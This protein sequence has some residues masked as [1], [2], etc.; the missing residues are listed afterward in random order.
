MSDLD[1]IQWDAPQSQP[2]ASSA[3]SSIKWDDSTPALPSA[4]ATP[5]VPF[6]TAAGG[7]ANLTP[8]QAQDYYRNLQATPLNA[9]APEEQGVMRRAVGGLLEPYTGIAA[10]LEKGAATAAD[11]L[12]ATGASK[13]LQNAAQNSYLYG[14]QTQPGVVSGAA[15]MVGGLPEMILPGAGSVAAGA[16]TAANELM[17]ATQNDQPL[18]MKELTTAL[19]SG[20][21]DAAMNYLLGKGVSGPIAKDL[22]RQLPMAL[23]ETGA[24]V[25]GRAG[26]GAILG[27][28]GQAVQ[29]LIHG[30]PLSTG[31]VGAAGQ[32]GA[33]E[34]GGGFAHDLAT[35]GSD[36][37]ARANAQPATNVPDT[38]IEVNGEN[39]PAASSRM[40]TPEDHD[41]IRAAM[42]SLKGTLNDTARAQSD[43]MAQGKEFANPEPQ[44]AGLSADEVAAQAAQVDPDVK[45]GGDDIGATHS[46]FKG[47]L[48][49]AHGANAKYSLQDIPLDS[50]K[51]NENYQP[52]KVQE[53][54]QQSAD[55]APPI[56]M[57]KEGAVVDGNTR[58]RAALARGDTTIKGY[59]PVTGDESISVKGQETAPPANQTTP[60]NAAIQE[61]TPFQQ[62]TLGSAVAAKADQWKQGV[63]EAWKAANRLMGTGLG[64]GEEEQGV[65]QRL[66]ATGSQIDAD[67][68]TLE[69]VMKPD[70]DAMDS[71][72]P[73]KR[74][75]WTNAVESGK[76]VQDAPDAANAIRT[77]N[78]SLAQRAEQVGIDTNNWRGDWVGRLAEWPDGT[79]GAGTTLAGPENYLKGR[80]LATF[81]DF[82]NAVEETGGRLTYDNPVDMYL[83]KAAEVNKSLT[84]REFLQ[85]EQDRGT[86]RTLG[87]GEKPAENEGRIT[88]PLGRE[89]RL[90]APKPI[91]DMLNQFI[92]P[93]IPKQ[94]IFARLAEVSRLTTGANFALSAFHAA[95]TG[96]SNAY[97]GVRQSLDN[98][99][100]GEFSLAAKNLGRAV[101][102]VGNVMW[103]NELR[104]QLA[105]MKDSPELKPLADAIRES[106]AKSG[107]PSILDRTSWQKA[108]NAYRQGDSAEAG[109]RFMQSGAGAISHVIMDKLVPNAKMA[110]LGMAAETATKRRLEGP[111]LQKYMQDASRLT[112]NVAGQVVRS[113]QFQH[114][115]VQN[116]M[117]LVMSA[118]K[119]AEG[120]IRV[121][122]GAAVDT[123]K[124]LSDVVQGNAP[125]ITA[126]QQA[127]L[128]HLLVHGTIAAV[129]QAMTTAA[130]GQMQLPSSFKDLWYPK[131]GRKNAD[132]S[133]ERLSLP[134]P[135]GVI[136]ALAAEGPKKALVN[137]INPVWRA[138]GD[139]ISNSDY[140]NVQ[141]RSGNVAEQALQSAGH[142]GKAILPWSVQQ[143]A[144]PAN[145]NQP[146]PSAVERGAAF[147]G[148]RK[149][150][151]SVSQSPAEQLAHEL[152]YAPGQPRPEADADRAST[153]SALANGIRNKEPDARAKIS[154]AVQSGTIQ[155]SDRKTIFERS[156]GPAGLAGTLYHSSLTP[157]QLMQVWGKAS[158]EE[159]QMIRGVV[160]RRIM[161]STS[162]SSDQRRAYRVQIQSDMAGGQ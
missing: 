120:A 31:L 46:Y 60:D 34:V 70:R 85:G 76:D 94:S 157:D 64:V 106:G 12:G 49:S 36:Q 42:E 128:A 61:K 148:V 47:E 48:D 136:P 71:W 5:T 152:S 13:A 40:P 107:T 100:H 33:M 41:Q 19:A 32:G 83:A 30:Q 134:D 23:G 88:D 63:G 25:V 68:A 11:A 89:D 20:G 14:A 79:K 55:T 98:V 90:V 138:I 130:N 109:L 111:E 99:M 1:S 45:N 22:I 153:I 54:S 105:G 160:T 86:V 43:Q 96:A 18:D 124:G 52:E 17:G 150:P 110:A 114:R 113:N 38:S 37:Q 115:M 16:N 101:N 135:L 91:A 62:R 77:M 155:N 112:D 144:Q 159:Q 119:F 69:Q 28:G 56:V 116:V 108:I 125:R 84:R 44:A 132:G 95:T 24:K 6:P 141:V 158:P 72:S 74:E 26:A 10:G 2:T 154:A 65:R 29:N 131:T 21:A 137:R 50:L 102:P 140:R 3:L 93:G 27:A 4:P 123:L 73:E 118:P 162:L 156:S 66:V 53:Y 126:N 67:R 97:L 39:V 58:A 80:K 127:V 146:E 78:E 161:Q 129:T 147:L 139:V 104:Q 81:S 8:E 121:Y 7:V 142:I 9:N 133:D 57:G 103:G 59:A 145:P 149:A 122:G 51:L 143:A 92:A 15:R 117:D 35:V 75:Q 82:K 87:Q 151:S